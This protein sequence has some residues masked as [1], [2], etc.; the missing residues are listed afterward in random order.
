MCSVRGSANDVLARFVMASMTVLSRLVVRAMADKDGCRYR[1]GI[2]A[3]AH[4]DKSGVEYG[5]ELAFRMVAL[6]R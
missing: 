6:S 5:L 4:L 1:F 3:A 2:D